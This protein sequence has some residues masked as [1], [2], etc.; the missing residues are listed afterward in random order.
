MKRN[1]L[2][3]SALLLS[4]FIGAQNIEMVMDLNPSGN[5]IPTNFGVATYR[6]NMNDVA[7]RMFFM[8]DDSTG[9]GVFLTD[10]T[11]SG[12]IKI[13]SNVTYAGNFVTVNHTNFLAQSPT[14][15]F[16]AENS[17]NGREVWKT[18]GTSQNTYLVKDIFTGTYSSNPSNIVVLNG[19]AY[20]AASSSNNLRS[21]YKSQ[22]T[23]A[24]TEIAVP[25][26]TGSNSMIPNIVLYNNSLIFAAYTPA[27]G[28]ELWISDGT[29][30]G[31]QLIKDI[32]PGN[33]NAFG[34]LYDFIKFEA[35]EY[36]GKLYFTAKN[37]ANNFEPWY[38]DGTANGT[39]CLK[40]V[41]SNGGSEAKNYVVC[42]NLL[43]FTAWDGTQY[44]LFSSNG[45]SINTNMILSYFLDPPVS[46]LY[47][48]QN[49]LFYFM[50]DGSLKRFNPQNNFE[51]EV[52][53]FSSDPYVAY[54]M[55][56]YGN[57]LYFRAYRNG[58]Y[59]LWRTDGTPANTVQ[60]QPNGATK[61]GS[62]GS[63]IIYDGS[64]YVAANFDDAGVELWKITDST[65][66]V[67]PTFEVLKQQIIYPNP[68]TDVLYIKDA[69][70][71]NIYI[72]N[73]LGECVFAATNYP[74]KS[75][76]V[77]HLPAGVYIVKN[78]HNQLIGK[79]IKR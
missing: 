40:E 69:N 28:A 32:N 5:S 22:A 60:I 12:T 51:D 42:N 74:E 68:A 63:M 54:E 35:V 33:L 44:G 43:Y 48:F 67:P 37:N 11:Q 73:M 10:G 30:S 53:Q 16:I 64:L 39:M 65:L 61:P 62:P 13:L 47:S 77:S 14:V 59:E 38:T 78:E 75:H 9:K 19:A 6:V 79:F 50:N 26:N 27:N 72:Y 49:N 21:L 36:N 41:N 52:Y 8:A 71:H 3:F 66:M 45:T 56:E 1:F 58:N 7:T 15:F 23:T 31:T 25:F 2:F 57:Y 4:G 76:Q 46:K 55:I 17:D 18:N 29:E 24:T 70:V 20:F 34:T